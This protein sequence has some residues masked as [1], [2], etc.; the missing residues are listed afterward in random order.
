MIDG[1]ALSPV[2]KQGKKERPA[3]DCALF[4]LE[5]SDRT[6]QELRKKLKEKG[7]LP[8]EIDDALSFLEEYQYVDDAEYAKRYIRSHSAQKS[9]RQIR[10]Q[11]EQKG[12]DAQWIDEGFAC[13]PV[14]EEAQILAWIRKKGC[15]PGHK[16]EW[17]QYR[18]VAAGL[19]RKGYPSEK[20]YKVMGTVW[21]TDA[22][23]PELQPD[24]PGI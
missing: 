20:I 12:I 4:M 7:Y 3:K 6:A 11:L 16:A 21:G 18:K 14:D 19:Y 2:A 8:E 9:I 24:P 5:R 1:K 10:M 22:Q 15:A 17:K 23:F 13:I